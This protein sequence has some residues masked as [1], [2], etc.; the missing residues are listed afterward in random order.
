MSDD[1]AISR[2]AYDAIVADLD[3]VITQSATVH[4][5]AWKEVFDEFLSSYVGRT[6]QS[7]EPFDLRTD[8]LKYVDGR[9]RYEGVKTFLESRGISLPWGSK[10]DPPDRETICGIGNHKNEKFRER[11][12]KEGVEVFQSSVDLL[13]Q[14]RDRGF[15]L[16]L[17]S[18]SK[19]ARVLLEAAD[20]SALFDAV[21][22]GV[23]AEKLH[24][25]GK[26]EP[27]TFEEAA[28]RLKAPPERAVVIEDAVSGVAAGRKGGFGCVIGV[29]RDSN[30]EELLGGGADVVVE[31]LE[32]LRLA[33]PDG[34]DR[35]R[36]KA[37]LPNAMEALDQLIETLGER[38]LAVF[39][40]FD[41]TLSPIVPRPQDAE[42]PLPTRAVLARLARCTPTAVVSGRDL[43]DVKPRVGIAEIWYAGSHGFEIQG[44]D[45]KH[46]IHEEARGALPSLDQAEEQLRR[47]VA[48]VSG[49][50]LE[51][52]GLSLAVHV[53]QVD[54][55][56][57]D[58]VAEDVRKVTADH[59]DLRLSTGRKVFDLGPDVDWH[60]GKAVEYIRDVQELDPE[61]TLTLHIGDDVTDEDVFE[62]LVDDGVAIAVKGGP[63]RTYATHALD[64]PDSVR[65][66][67]DKLERLLMEAKRCRPGI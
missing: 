7:Q 45:S 6:G 51:R 20:V 43:D 60:K 38:R 58:V 66:Y 29:A 64:D 34:A 47:V 11:I 61:H 62:M 16:A 36:R 12:R 17:V 52:K 26:P 5:A 65:E 9:P 44:P 55:K 27:D 1:P 49:A 40:D 31:D 32:E 57:V 46:F 15:R 28:K 13:K 30:R 2:D 14:A 50:S 48:R 22:D 59:P 10:D 33:D 25:P 8:Y 21:I 19:N 35:P 42:L 56:L 18:S 23:E 63:E 41:G 3:G 53:R 39:L 54:P 4:A 67:L 37:D 24:L